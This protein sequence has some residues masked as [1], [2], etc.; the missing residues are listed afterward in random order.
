M[1]IPKINNRQKK[2]IAQIIV[3]VSATILL[4]DFIYK[5]YKDISQ[6]NKQKCILYLT[7]P[8][9]GFMFYE[10]FLEL[11]FV[12][13]LGIF[14]AVLLERWFSKY[15]KFYP[16][17]PITA[18]L[19]GSV[20]PVC[21]CSVIPIVKSMKEKINM[22]TLVTFIIAAPLLN[23]Y[24]I[25][26]SY[27]VLG[28]QYGTLRIISSFVLSISAGYIVEW[29]YKRG[30][31]EINLKNIPVAKEN[32]AS[33]FVLQP[34]IFVQ[35]Y[36]IVLSIVPFIL[37]AGV[38]GVVT[39]LFVPVNFLKTYSHDNQFLSLILIV[40]IGI[41]LYYCNGADVVFLKPI[42][43]HSGLQ[44]G[45]AMAFSLTSTAICITAIVM[46]SKFIG[47]KLTAILTISIAIMSM[48]IGYGINMLIGSIM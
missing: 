24:I 40:V 8:K 28:W 1:V 20:I 29:F 35:T 39:E 42:I 7:M 41:P 4:A 26:L 18:F 13:V 33:C 19:Y 46:M 32:K 22:K 30:N 44:L 27:S 48:L 12:I 37:I 25:V 15:Q 16:R 17:N 34:N 47:T 31:S 3:I 45:S 43:T 21:S 5:T 36:D 10:Y 23:P 2:R 11:F 6:I 9:S 14:A 38:L